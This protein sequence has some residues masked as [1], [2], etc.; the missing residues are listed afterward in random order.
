MVFKDRC[1]CVLCIQNS[2]STT[3]VN[4]ELNRNMVEKVTICSHPYVDLR[5][6]YVRV[7]FYYF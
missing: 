5:D 2:L 7:L 4:N 1:D 3:R 6:M